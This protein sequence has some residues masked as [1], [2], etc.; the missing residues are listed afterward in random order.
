MDMKKGL[1]TDLCIAL[2][3][4]LFTYSSISKFLDLKNFIFQMYRAPL[5]LMKIMAPVLGWLIPAIESLIVIGLFSN[6]FRLRA[7]Y[8]SFALLVLFELY[9]TGM[10]LS[11]L[12]LPCSCGGVIAQMSW[13]E[14]IPF[15]AFFIALTFYAIYEI[16]ASGDQDK[17]KEK[18]FKELSRA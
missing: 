7:L 4:L 10:I 6:R 18:K 8:A 14:H 13:K 9:I 1:M 12:H 16:K 15:N 2:I 11:G 3:L 5:P 17:N